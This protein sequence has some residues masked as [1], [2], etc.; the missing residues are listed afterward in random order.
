MRQ[1]HNFLF[2]SILIVAI[3]VRK[4]GLNE[5]SLAL[6]WCIVCSCMLNMT[7]D[8]IKNLKSRF[9][10]KCKICNYFPFLFFQFFSGFQSYVQTYLTYRNVLYLK[11]K[12]KT[13]HFDLMLSYFGLESIFCEIGSRKSFSYLFDPELINGKNCKIWHF[14]KKLFFSF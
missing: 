9:F 3:K 7:R 10:N 2:H 5:M 12:L 14:L 11:S 1:L 6:F 4:L 8:M 13:F